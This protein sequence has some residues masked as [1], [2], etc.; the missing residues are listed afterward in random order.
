[1]ASVG[2]R[3]VRRVNCSWCCSL[4][5]QVFQQALPSGWLRVVC[6]I[7]WG[8]WLVTGNLLS[9]GL[10][11]GVEGRKQGCV[12]GWD[13]QSPEH[14][15]LLAVVDTDRPNRSSLQEPASLSGVSTPS[16][17]YAAAGRVSVVTSSLH[18]TS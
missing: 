16:C 14:T 7:G 17:R 5:W 4:C 8:C 13:L 6:V 10:G 11:L 18:T 3:A 12:G 15:H 2:R 1:M 9:P